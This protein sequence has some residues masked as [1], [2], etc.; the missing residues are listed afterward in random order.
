MP[1]KID[2]YWFEDAPNPARPADKVI[3][4]A[5]LSNALRYLREGKPVPSR[6]A[7]VL[8]EG[9]EDQL[10]GFPPWLYG[11][12][13][14]NPQLKMVYLA[15][16]DLITNHKDHTSDAQLAETLDLSLDKLKAQKQE[17][18]AWIKHSKGKSMAD[19]SLMPH[20]FNIK[21][22]TTEHNNNYES[23]ING[24]QLEIKELNVTTS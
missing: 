2:K 6:T 12:Q 4:N 14:V 21:I 22:L 18:R 7:Q 1:R 8:I 9:I 20:T 19:L 16:L 3:L 23:L 13:G 10:K 11:K 5:Q 15:Y 17:M 24:A